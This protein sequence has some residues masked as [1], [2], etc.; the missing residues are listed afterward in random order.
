M[1]YTENEFF[2]NIVRRITT[3]EADK[4]DYKKSDV[5][6]AFLLYK[7]MYPNKTRELLLLNEYQQKAVEAND[8]MRSI[9]REYRTLYDRKIKDPKTFAFYYYDPLRKN[10]IRISV[11]LQLSTIP[12]E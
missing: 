11:I 10:K 1:A 8:E 4:Y 7:K 3:M 9:L 6:E 5:I 12:L 2:N